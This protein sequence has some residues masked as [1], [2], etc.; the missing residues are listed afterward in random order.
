MGRCAL[1]IASE[2][3]DQTIGKASGH[4]IEADHALTVDRARDGKRLP[5]ALRSLRNDSIIKKVVGN[6][7]GPRQLELPPFSFST[8]S[9]GL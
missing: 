4:V 3:A 9:P 2:Q 6:H 5:Y 1:G 7:T 8:A